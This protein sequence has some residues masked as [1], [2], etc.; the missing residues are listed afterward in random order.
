M[1]VKTTHGDG[2]MRLGVGTAARLIQHSARKKMTYQEFPPKLPS[3]EQLRA[4]VQ[5]LAKKEGPFGTVARLKEAG[6]FVASD[7]IALQAVA[8]AIAS[9]AD[10]SPLHTI[11]AARLECARPV[12]SA[13][14]VVHNRAT[15]A[16]TGEARLALGSYLALCLLDNDEVSPSASANLFLAIAHARPELVAGYFQAK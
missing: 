14:Q 3:A 8:H 10:D 1:R 13:M 2:T 7:S 6:R 16:D 5:D 4:F 15:L 12:W 9:V 11:P